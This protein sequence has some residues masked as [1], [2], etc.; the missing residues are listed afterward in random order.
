M[1]HVTELIEV[2]VVWKTYRV[3]LLLGGEVMVKV[4]VRVAQRFF[5]RLTDRMLGWIGLDFSVALADTARMSEIS[6]A[7]WLGARPTIEDLPALRDAGITH[8]VSCLEG[9]ARVAFLEERVQT[10]FLP[11]RDGIRQDITS[12]FPEFFAFAAEA[13]AEPGAKVFVHCEV[14]VSRSAT[15]VLALRMQ[16]RGAR[17]LEAFE[18]VRARRTKI[19]PNIGFA[20]Q[21]QRLEHSLLGRRVGGPSSL[22][23]YLRAYCNV[24]VESD[25]LED[26]LVRHDFDAF[27]AIQAL[28]GD[29]IPRVIQGV[30]L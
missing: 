21:L 24:P 14:G 13:Q 9:S 1:L 20:S 28:F 2:L 3:S 15:L 11:M 23:Q 27:R 25:V 29:D 4:V 30:R 7:L 17:F 5:E 6:E 8:V 19:L 12:A 10:L 22:T 18:A 26:M 16:T